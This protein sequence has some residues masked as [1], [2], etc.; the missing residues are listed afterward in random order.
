VLLRDASSIALL[1]DL[2][3]PLDFEVKPLGKGIHTGDAHPMEAAGNLVG[4][5]F[6]LS[7]RVQL[8]HHHVD[9]I[10]AVDGRVRA[11]GYPPAV[12]L[13]RDGVVDVNDQLDVGADARERLVHRVVHDLINEVMQAIS[14]GVTHIH[15]GALSDCFQAFQDGY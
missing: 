9:G 8:G 7:S 1:V 10:H 2:P 15:S 12:V 3:V 11:D 13:D 5:I 14:P 6:E 4:G